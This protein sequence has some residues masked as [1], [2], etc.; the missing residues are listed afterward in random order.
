MDTETV[1][2]VVLGVAMLRN[3]ILVLNLDA[4][5]TVLLHERSIPGLLPSEDAQLHLS[6]RSFEKS[7]FE[8]RI[9]R[10]CWRMKK[11]VPLLGVAS[12]VS[13]GP[14]TARHVASNNA[15]FACMQLRR[16]PSWFNVCLFQ[17]YLTRM[18]FTGLPGQCSFV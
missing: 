8:E 14:V 15:R 7:T 1:E 12:W 16:Q 3:G 4:L 10:G 5:R 9:E 11:E 17:L 6:F 18:E 13:A 2:F